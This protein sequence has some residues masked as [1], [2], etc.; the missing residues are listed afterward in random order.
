MQMWKSF[1]V[2]QE[3]KATLNDIIAVRTPIEKTIFLSKKKQIQPLIEM[4]NLHN[5]GFSHGKDKQKDVVDWNSSSAPSRA[6]E[7]TRGKCLDEKRCK[8]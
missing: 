8:E 4:R 5:V 6:S 7:E 2:K 1:F 3:Y